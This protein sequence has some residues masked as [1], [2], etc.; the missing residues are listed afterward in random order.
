MVSQISFFVCDVGTSNEAVSVCHWMK[1]MK[2]VNFW[3]NLY[4]NEIVGNS[5]IMKICINFAIIGYH[6]SFYIFINVD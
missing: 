6:F 2:K 4:E 3:E 1:K 5:F